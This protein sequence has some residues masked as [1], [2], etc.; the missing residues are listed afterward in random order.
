MFSVELFFCIC[1]AICEHEIDLD[2]AKL[3]VL[4]NIDIG[5]LIMR[6]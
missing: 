1:P 4:S 3:N 2:H 6:Q 5:Q